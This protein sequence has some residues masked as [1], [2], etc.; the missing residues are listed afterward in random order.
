M[1]DML[2]SGLVGHGS[3]F[4]ARDPSGIRPLYYYSNDE[5]IVAAS[6]RPPIKTAFG[7]EFSE[8]KE[9]DPG[10]SLI[11]NKD[12]NYFIEKFVEPKEKKSCSFERI[13]FS[14]GNDPKIYKERKNLGKYLI[15]QIL[16][17]I[18]L[19]L[20]DTIFSYIPNTAETCFVGLIDGLKDYIIKKK[21]DIIINK[22][23]NGESLEDV[24]S[25]KVRIEKLVSKDVKMRTF[26]AD[27][28][29]RNELVSNVYDTTHGIVIPKKRYSCNN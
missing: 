28:D 5:I 11:I 20:K 16:D 24:L 18:D 26:I 21:K 7:C 10:H 23:P 17:A 1:G 9:V 25:S 4:I 2:F 27:D 15:P 13:Y 6:E 19:N 29:S 12:G 3:S 14:R 22:N 8:I